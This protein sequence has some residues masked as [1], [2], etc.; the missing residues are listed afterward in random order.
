MSD[1]HARYSF[2]IP[3]QFWTKSK[4]VFFYFFLN[5]FLHRALRPKIL[6]KVIKMVFPFKLALT[7]LSRWDLL[8]RCVFDAYILHKWDFYI[9]KKLSKSNYPSFIL[10]KCWDSCSLRNSILIRFGIF[11]TLKTWNVQ[12][13]VF[14][15]F[16]ES[17][18]LNS[19]FR[20]EKNN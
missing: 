12:L 11:V 14:T 8:I 6:E 13:T 3:R 10:V 17:L 5:F 18:S 16:Q 20:T 1:R 7:C 9:T 15:I 19:N 4:G 2:E